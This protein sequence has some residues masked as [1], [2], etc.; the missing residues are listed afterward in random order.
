MS[1]PQ[2]TYQYISIPNGSTAQF[3]QSSPATTIVNHNLTD[4]PGYDHGRKDRYSLSQKNSIADDDG[5][6][7]I[8]RK[9]E[10]NREAARKCRERKNQH[11]EVLEGRLQEQRRAIELMQDKMRLVHAE[12]QRIGDYITQNLPHSDLREFHRI[13]SEIATCLELHDAEM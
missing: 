10:R 3:L 9:R 11:V 5:V 4:M 7:R 1:Y 6:K 12:M 13:E 2:S 8:E